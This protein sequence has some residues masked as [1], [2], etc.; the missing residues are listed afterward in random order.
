MHFKKNLFQFD[1]NEQ[2][3]YYINN[4][5]H[6]QPKHSSFEMLMMQLILNY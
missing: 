5:T 4:V 2:S 1:V 3:M 6:F